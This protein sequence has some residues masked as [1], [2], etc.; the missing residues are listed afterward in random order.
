MT[1]TATRLINSMSRRDVQQK[2]VLYALALI[3]LGAIAFVIYYVT[4]GS[5]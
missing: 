2:L 1:D 3:I 4:S 5:K